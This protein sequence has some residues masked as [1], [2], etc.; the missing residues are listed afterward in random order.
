M[1]SL[2]SDF[3]CNQPVANI[4]HGFRDDFISHVPSIFEKLNIQKIK[5]LM[6]IASDNED[7]QLVKIIGN[8]YAK[9]NRA[10]LLL[11]DTLNIFYS[12][13]IYKKNCSLGAYLIKLNIEA[14]VDPN[15]E[16]PLPFSLLSLVAQ[17]RVRDR[18]ERKIQYNLINFLRYNGALLRNSG[19]ES[20]LSKIEETNCRL[21]SK[22]FGNQFF[23]KAKWLYAGSSDPKSPLS[24]IPPDVII[25]ILKQNICL[26]ITF[27]NLP[28]RAVS[29][30]V[31]KYY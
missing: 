19:I 8:Y 17:D 30:G 28:F 27:Q 13:T 7:E 21:A 22:T 12:H 10:K 11:D 16:M 20:R 23:I 18:E 25:N 14:G 5:E 6:K 3:L 4:F 26:L 29:K 15:I 24:L 31:T 2:S 1:C 9:K